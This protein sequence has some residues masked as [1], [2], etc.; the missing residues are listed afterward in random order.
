MVAPKQSNV[1][2]TPARTSFVDTVVRDSLPGGDSVSRADGVSPSTPGSHC[3]AV[4]GHETTMDVT[5]EAVSDAFDR[6]MVVRETALEDVEETIAAY[7]EKRPDLDIQLDVEAE[8][9]LPAESRPLLN[10]VGLAPGCVIENVYVMPGIPKELKAMFE[11]VIEAF[12]GDSISQFLYTVEPE[13]NIVWA[14]DEMEESFDV[15]VGC[16][17][18]REAGHNRLKITATDE[19]TLE[20]AAKWLKEHVDASENSVSRDWS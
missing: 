6:E 17:P 14:L 13:S 16:Y 11:D 3:P 9:S 1:F 19:Q 5:M 10:S 20:A 2:A 7:M 15:S 18:D 12:D 4:P 8:A